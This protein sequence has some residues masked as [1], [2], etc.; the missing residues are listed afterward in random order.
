MPWVARRRSLAGSWS[1]APITCWCSKPIHSK[2]FLAVK[3][4]ALF[5]SWRH[6]QAGVRCLRR[7]SWPPGS[8]ARVR[9]PASRQPGSAA[10]L[11]RAAHRAGGGNHPRGSGKVEAEIRYFLS[12]CRDDPTVLVQAI[13]RHW[14]IE[15]V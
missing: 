12:S 11:A 14:T 13:R 10:R 15:K 6:G 1:A 3:E 8:P 9:L 2:A 7:Q 4:W 5:C